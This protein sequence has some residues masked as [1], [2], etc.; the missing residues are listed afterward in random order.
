MNRSNAK[1]FNALKQ[2]FRKYAKDF[3]DA[4]TKY[5]EDPEGAAKLDVEDDEEKPTA[6]KEKKKK[7][8]QPQ[9]EDQGDDE[10][11][12]VAKGK[13]RTRVKTNITYTRPMILSKLKEVMIQRGKKATNHSAQI[14]ELRTLVECSPDVPTK[15]NVL[16]VLVAALFDKNGTATY[17]S[18]EQ[19]RSAH[20]NL[21]VILDLIES[22]RSLKIVERNEV[23]VLDAGE[24][25]TEDADVSQD[26]NE[27]RIQG[28]LLA[29]AERLDDEFVKSTQ[30]I[31]PHTQEYV[32]R[33]KDE[34]LF[35]LLAVRLQSYYERLGNE[36]AI[37]H[38][39]L[40]RIERLY[41]KRESM[42]P[43][44]KL[45]TTYLQSLKSVLQI[46]NTQEFDGTRSHE[47]SALTFAQD[48]AKK[49][50]DSVNLKTEEIREI[51]GER[52]M[53]ERE[54]K[55]QQVVS[56][57]AGVIYKGN[58]GRAKTRA[59]LCQVYNLALEEEYYQARDMLLMSH[60]QDHIQH[61]DIPTQIL[62]NRALVQIGLCAFRYGLIS[63]AHSC[64]GDLFAAGRI[65]ELLA[66]GLVT[67][68]YGN[69]QNLEQ[70]KLAK[71]RQ[72]PYHMHIST[73]MTDAVHLIC[74]MLLEV[75][76]MALNHLDPKKKILSRPYRRLLE[77]HERQV[78]NGPPENTHDFI[79]AASRC[80]AKGEV[81]ECFDMLQNLKIWALLPNPEPVKQ[82][83]RRKIC[84]EGL[85]TYLFTYS[86]LY[87][88]ISS[89]VLCEMFELAPTEVHSIVSRMIV[90]EELLASW[91]QP[92]G[93]IVMHRADPTRLQYLSMQFAE[94]VS[95]LV[96]NNEKLFETH[97]GSRDLQ[98][99]KQQR[100]AQ[101]RHGH[102]RG[103]D[104]RER[105]G[106]FD[107]NN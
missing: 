46:E 49:Y 65:K 30:S 40:R 19:W 50:D 97:I 34:N 7:A 15:L 76:N 12:E 86:H 103:H 106:H 71:L 93:S 13:G 28:S 4:M 92:T 16:V 22:N 74:A 66:Q 44:G 70:E 26:T 42:N 79:M 84:E 89:S 98:N 80:L 101:S 32:E 83:L 53:R 58:D 47:A 8:P 59:I 87:R 75:P 68:R 61:T 107:T 9:V 27:V 52:G 62:Y 64:L 29:F 2:K 78:F 3:N 6:P 31:D 54:M 25:F 63:E 10:D 88:S 11:W 18:A 5:R 37:S 72:L 51:V 85:R 105:W 69:P 36:F 33:L 94:K 81:R 39:A 38:L 99:R 96:D 55:I 14:F 73:D 67:S 100:K 1:S 56:E 41:Y 48:W 43:L 95:V 23:Q 24:D 21:M 82:V 20:G 90:N 102:H 77:Y 91:D 35:L 60:L 45:H 104:N 57:L 17:V